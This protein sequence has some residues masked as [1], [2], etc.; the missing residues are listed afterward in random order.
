MGDFGLNMK[1]LQKFCK[2]SF[3]F[4]VKISPTPKIK[5]GDFSN[6]GGNPLIPLSRSDTDH[7]HVKNMY[8]SGNGLKVTSCT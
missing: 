1:V 7:G 6:Y 3:I 8:L 4:Y 5:W 2:F